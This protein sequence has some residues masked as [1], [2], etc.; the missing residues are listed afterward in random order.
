MCTLLCQRGRC[1]RDLS[2]TSSAV[3]I[4]FVLCNPPG[5]LEACDDDDDHSGDDD[6]D[7]VTSE[8]RVY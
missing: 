1:S 7:D 2:P 4:P 6:D 5:M 3:H 8:P